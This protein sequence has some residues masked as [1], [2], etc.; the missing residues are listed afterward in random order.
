MWGVFV[1]GYIEERAMEIARY[2]IDNNATVRQAAVHFGISKATVHKDM[3]TRLF[4]EAPSLYAAVRQTLDLN[5]AQRHMRGGEATRRK[6]ECCRKSAQCGR[7]KLAKTKRK[8]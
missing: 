6:Y 1:K 7:E 3:T 8:Q 5:K 2:I 4:Y